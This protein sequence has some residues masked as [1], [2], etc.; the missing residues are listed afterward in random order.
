VFDNVREDL[1][2]YSRFCYGGRPIWRVLPRLLYGHPASAAVIWHRL[3]SAAWQTRVPVV[4]QL[5]Q[6]SYLIGLVFVRMY[7]GVQ[8]PPETKIGPGLIILHFGG[9][10][11][12]RECEIGENCVLY[13]NVNIVTMKNRQGARIG[14]NFYAGVGTTIIGDIVIEDDVTVGAG[15]VV[16]KS[17]PAD[18][19]VAG[20][21]ARILRA[22]H[23]YENNAENKTARR[24]PPRWME[25]PGQKTHQQSAREAQRDAT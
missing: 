22:R 24:Q 17:I 18:V 9:V 5:L 13:H 1:R 7:S 11:I 16:T 8:I 20:S 6:V 15:S 3:G 10:I 4:K 25:C 23:D 19:I 21:P 12:T 14:A 2:H